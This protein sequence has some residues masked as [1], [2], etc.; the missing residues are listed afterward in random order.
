MIT[1]PHH[2]VYALLDPRTSEVR[3]IGYTK[4]RITDRLRGHVGNCKVST[5]KSNWIKQLKAL[6]LRP[7]SR[8]LCIL[9]SE[10]EALRIEVAVIALYRSRGVRLTNST[11]GGEGS[12]NLLPE[13]RERIVKGVKASMTPER[14]AK[15]SAQVTKQMTGSK[16]TEETK[17]KMRAAW[18]RRKAKG[19]NPLKGRK[20]PKEICEKI[21]QSH[22]GKI[23]TDECKEKISATRKEKFASG[24]YLDSYKRNSES[25]RFEPSSKGE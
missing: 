24:G 23:Q 19:C 7:K 4:N 15:I 5:Y 8:A 9:S 13:I 17:K 18:E 3:Y 21:S 25:G 10:K 16:R 12:V 20:R 6:G 22:L 1:A 11:D 14:R 2:S